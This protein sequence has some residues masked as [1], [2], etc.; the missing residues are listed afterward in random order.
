[1]FVSL[2]VGLLFGLGIS[3]AIGPIS[4]LIKDRVEMSERETGM[5]TFGIMMVLAGIV[6]SILTANTSAFWLALGGT[7]GAFG[8]RLYAVAADTIM[9][10]K[11]PVSD[12]VDAVEDAAG[13]VKDA[14]VDAKD[15]AKDA[16]K[17]KS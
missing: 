10:P 12:A 15:A 4:D 8:L 16:V 14:A 5:I 1:M 3:F 2:I 6:A 17:S 13:D 7:I 11:S 9:N